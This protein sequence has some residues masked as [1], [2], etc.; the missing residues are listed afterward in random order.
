MK[1]TK[2]AF[3]RTTL[4]CAASLIPCSFF[5]QEAIHDPLLKWMNQIAQRQLQA[6][7]R[8]IDQIHTVADADR[9]KQEVR[10]KLL[11]LLGGLPNY[12]GPL[13]AKITGQI[14]S[15]DYTIEKVLFQSLP[16]FYVTA[17]L[18][19]PNKPG[20]YPAILYQSGHT[21]EGK[22]EPQR[23]AANLALRGFVVLAPDPIG[24][25]ERE[26]TYDPHIS[27]ALAGWSVPEHIQSGAESILIGESAARFFIW[28][29]K[30]GIDY[31]VSRPDVDPTRLGAAGC[32]GGGAL[33]TFIGAMDPRLKAVVPA[34]YPNSYQLLFAGPDPD[35]EMSFPNF[36]ARGLDVADFVEVTAPTPWLIQETEE[37]YFTPAGARMVYEEARHWYSIY[38]AEDKIGFFVGPGPHGTPLV[39]REAVYQWMI[40]WL[41]DGQGDFH[42]Q[43]VHLYNNFE[44][45]VT[46]TGHV[47]DIPGSRKVYQLILDDFHAKEHP[48]TMPELQA[49]LRRL[50]IPTDGGSPE[51]AVLDESNTAEFYRLHIKFAVESGVEIEGSLYVPASPEGRK[52]AVL[53]VEDS[54]P[55]FQAATTESLASRIARKGRVVL[56]LA[57]R[58]SPGENTHAP[59]V[60]NWITNSRANQIGLNLPAMRAHDILRGIDLLAARSDVDAAS[61]HAS[62]RGV[63]GIWLLLAA[64]AD[65]R[66]GKVWLDRTPYSLRAALQN[67]L[68]MNLFDAVIPGF[69]LHWDLDDLTKAM[70]ARPVMWT[71]PANWMNR[72]VSLHGPYEYRYILGD[73]TDLADAQDDAYL[74]EFLK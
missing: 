36:L 51:M 53:M 12:H 43:P 26:Q 50:E 54:G 23:A 59:F 55:Y 44:L 67:T 60:G 47:D 71:D 35:T 37:D 28:D 45:L 16:N 11:E 2:T 31:L 58:D 62:A 56:T 13:N 30:R 49:E 48:G 17:D 69:A 19:R 25:G 5:A 27:G 33:T 68:N 7:Q 63:K 32:S 1:L 46:P 57:P 22:P 66:I 14:K 4:L 21:Q 72:I 38:G 34:C 39:S 18:Y 8:A 52:P 64:A 10:A 73:T 40:R 70:G 42:E 65:P 29:A 24:Q 74:E 15:D 3:L 6:R 20:R 61:I 41:K 9:R